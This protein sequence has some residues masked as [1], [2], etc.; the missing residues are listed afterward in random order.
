MPVDHPRHVRRSHWRRGLA[1]VLIAAVP[2]SG[3]GGDE[4]VDTGGSEEGIPHP[5]GL[6][7]V[8]QVRRVGGLNPRLAFA[9]VPRATVLG[10]GTMIVEGAQIAI[11]P[12][13]LLP[14]LFR[15]QLSEQGVQDLL[16]AADGAG[17][18]SPPAA[19]G[20][21]PIADATTTI[22]TVHARDQVVSHEIYALSEAGPGYPGL[23]ER[24]GERREAVSS[25]LAALTVPERQLVSPEDVGEPAPFEADRFAIRAGPVQGGEEEP[26]GGIEPQV[27]D[28][29][30]PEVD[31][32]QAGEC[33]LVEGERAERLVQVLADAN[34]LTRFRQQ[35][36]VH[37]LA[38]RPL[39]PG[40][41]TC[42]AVVV[43]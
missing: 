31:L 37:T 14:S 21:P 30:L 17:L 22:V 4:V 38:V 10:D 16:E 41:E 28:W 1:V 11:F 36:A 6:E 29:P 8:L 12:P 19:Y 40:E 18:L 15:V 24:Q 2:V 23:T 27:V 7:V 26:V 5:E 43:D 13:P 35:D 20:E 39:L 9:E 3:C 34:T 25:F 42:D 33:V 32:A